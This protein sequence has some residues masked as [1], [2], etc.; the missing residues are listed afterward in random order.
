M[1]SEK[2]KTCPVT[3]RKVVEIS[4][5]VTIKPLAK[6]GKIELQCCGKPTIKSGENPKGELDGTCNF[7]ITQ[8]I[9]VEI[10]I[11][12]SAETTTGETFV[13]SSKES[14]DKSCNKLCEEDKDCDDEEEDEDDNQQNLILLTK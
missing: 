5:P 14:F 7:T 9:C 4:V 12:F 13:A 2:T 11:D 1:S 3:G 10:P 8:K 6:V